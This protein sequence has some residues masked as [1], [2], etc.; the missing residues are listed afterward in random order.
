MNKHSNVAPRRASSHI[1]VAVSALCAALAGQAHAADTAVTAAADATAA[2][3]L[4]G[5]PIATVEIS[6]HKTRS[7]VSMG[8]AEI[9][10]IIPGVN[11]L[12]ALETL[13]G[14]SFQTAD[15]WGNN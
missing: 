7:T 8:S 3:P 5:A 11:P 12:K 6:S 9:Q 2:A 15:P 14:V 4:D 10:K 13:P 1:A